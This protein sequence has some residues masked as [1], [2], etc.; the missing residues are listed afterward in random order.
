M[1]SYVKGKMPQIIFGSKSAQKVSGLL[2]N[3]EIKKCL[4]V[5]GHHVVRHSITQTVLKDLSAAGI[6]CDV[7]DRV[8]PEP[9]D[10]LCLEI[11]S[12]IRTNK[13]DCVLGIGGGSPMDAAKAA[14][15]ISGIPEDISDLH[16][17]GKTGSRMKEAWNR[18]CMLILMPTTSGTGAET[19]ASAVITSTMHGMK[20]S[21]GNSNISADIAVIDPEFT[22]GMPAAPTVCGGIDALA[23]T[24]EILVGTANNEYTNQ[25]LFLCLE[26]IWKWLPVAVKEP[27]NLEAREQMSWAAHNALANGGV[28][29]GHAVAHAIGALYHIT[30]GHACAMVLPTVV[31]HF[32]FYAQENI[33]K[34]AEIMGISIT[35]DAEKD[36]AEVAN[37]IHIFCQQLG[38]DTLQKTF[39]EK[40]Y[41]DSCQEFTKK[42]I[43]LI[44]DDFK[45]RE[46]IPPIH[47]GNYEEKVGKICKAIYMEK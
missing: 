11:A 22:V 5:T 40:G 27:E 29:N 1:E 31:R 30:H 42:M 37:A 20:F 47:T 38:L 26:K 28:P 17:Y 36:A 33:Q 44:M 24:V 18:P 8:T 45:S 3:Y 13:Y 41:H 9:T 34:M 4:L 2:K 15:L 43:P 12:E 39:A 16:E 14:T 46:W 23:H 21:F 10:T 35:G 19:T 7:F 6:C 32:A 25:I